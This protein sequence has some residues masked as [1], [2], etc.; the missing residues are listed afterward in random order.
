MLVA[1][2]VVA[3]RRAVDGALQGDRV[4]GCRAEGGRF[5]V[6]ESAPAVTAGQADQVVESIWFEGDL[7]VE[8]PLVGQGA[9]DEAPD[10][11]VVE[12]LQ[13]EQQ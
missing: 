4:D 2:P 1:V 3:D 7:P 9:L 11:V 5:Q 13:G 12:R 6:S 10:V 8:A